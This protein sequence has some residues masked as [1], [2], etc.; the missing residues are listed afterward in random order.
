MNRVQLFL[1]LALLTVVALL[2]AAIPPACT[3][4]TFYYSQ[5]N[6]AP[7]LPSSWNTSRTGGGAP[8]ANFTSGDIFVIQNGHTM[9]TAA[10]WSISGNGSKLWIED[11]GTLT[12]NSAVTLTPATTFRIDAGGTYVHNNTS[13]YGS[14]IFQGTESFDPASTVVLNNSNAT[15]PSNVA[16]GHLTINFTSDPGGSVNCS[17]GLTTINGNLTIQSTSVR[18]LRLSGSTAYTLNLAGNLTITGGTLNLASGSNSGIVY[19]LNLGGSF[20]QTG[21]AFLSGNNSSPASLVFTGGSSAVT[22]ATSG[23]TFTN[24]NLNWQIA[25]GKTVALNTHFGA[26]SWVAG[27]RTMSVNGALQI[28]QGADPGNSGIW[29]YGAGATLVFNNASGSYSVNDVKW[30]PATGGP[31]NVTIQGGGLTLNVARTINGVFATTAPVTNGGNLT[32]NGTLQIDAG[33]SFSAP[34]RY[35]SASLLLYRSGGV[36]GRGAEWGAGTA[37]PGYPANVQISNNTVL[38]YPNGSPAAHNLSGNLTIAAGSELRMDYGSPGLN[39]PLTVGGDVTLNGALTL[40]DAAGGDLVVA[41]AWTNNGTFD[42]RGRAVIFNGAS[43]DQTIGGSQRTDFGDLSIAGG[44]TVVVL[45]VD[46]PTVAGLVTNDGT[47]KQTQTVDN[48]TA[49]FLHLTDADGDTDKYLGVDIATEDDLGSTVVAVAGNQVCSQIPNDGLPVRRCYTV[50]PATSA[51][52]TVTFYFRQADLQV[53]QTVENLNVWRYD[54]TTWQAVKRAG[55]ASECV[56]GAIDCWVSGTTAVFSPFVLK[57]HS[58]LAVQLAALTA[59][60][61][62]RGVTLAWETVTETDNA[63][64]TLYRSAGDRTG[65]T[66]TC[67]VCGWIKLNAAL[68]PSATPG[69][70]GG[71]TYTWRDTTAQRGTRYTYRLDALDQSGSAAVLGTAVFVPPQTFLPWVTR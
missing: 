21:G 44:A 27:N 60:P 11:G 8:P 56:L 6:L 69:S 54:D 58:P 70:S 45:A 22:F 57:V 47:L 49:Q 48:A 51:A 39:Q 59:A 20:N 68:I 2:S 31:A 67:Q 24:G 66:G 46:P 43:A 3:A 32:L 35:G 7:E 55:N 18:E 64:F 34:P 28:N 61:S 25:G 9:T 36:Y 17:G 14:T 4:W 30:W 37:Q 53:G 15:G 40:G 10:A 52:A 26:G 16:F 65:F 29:T 33:G 50:T 38:N 19:A 12:A 63:G 41:G 1:I 5:G 71:Q 42:S 13:A 23:G 62:P